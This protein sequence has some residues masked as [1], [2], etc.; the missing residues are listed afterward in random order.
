MRRSLNT[1]VI[2]MLAMPL[3]AAS[4]SATPADGT[5]Y[6]PLTSPQKPNTALECEISE[7]ARRKIEKTRALPNNTYEVLVLI[8]KA[9]AAAGPPECDSIKARL[10]ADEAYL[11]ALQVG[12]STEPSPRRLIPDRH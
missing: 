11:L 1:V 12:T 7:D 10:L 3:L 9:E 2:L 8:A 4:N 5:E 6:Q